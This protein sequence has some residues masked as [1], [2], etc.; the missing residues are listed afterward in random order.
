MRR[1]VP[2]SPP[3]GGASGVRGDASSSRSPIHPRRRVPLLHLIG[4]AT[5]AVLARRT[6]VPV[7]TYDLPPLTHAVR[8]DGS[9]TAEVNGLRLEYDAFGEPGDPTVVLVM[10]LAA[11]MVAW[12]EEFCCRLASRG[13]RVIRFDNRDI[14]RSTWLDHEPVPG[15]VALR[16][17]LRRGEPVTVP[18]LLTDMAAD[19]VGLM[20][21][22]G[23]ASAHLVGVSMGGMI[24]QTVA[25]RAP[26]RVRTLTSIMSNTGDPDLPRPHW[27]A[28]GAMLVPSRGDREGYLRRAVLVWRILTGPEVAVD[29][30]RTRVQSETA[31]GRGVH[32]AGAARQ[33]AAILA[34]PPRSAD[35]RAVRVPTL[36]IHGDV[37]WLVP[38]EGG[39]R[40]AEVIPGAE[41]EIIRG[42]GH[43]M[44]PPLWERIIDRIAAL[45]ARASS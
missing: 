15:V 19:V 4:D 30:R 14:G 41:L 21:A 8:R 39:R 20:D 40:T 44:S 37:D 3:A 33:L 9:A 26:Q 42:M 36:V 32:P 10:G 6:P 23:I 18:Y 12:D 28:L 27:R 11:Q 17:S 5:L 45:A 2:L 16:R 34:S 38:V 13:F 1:G 43:A 7:E 24:A 29:L 31:Y 22:L 25:I 35:L